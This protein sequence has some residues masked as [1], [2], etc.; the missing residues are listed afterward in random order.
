MY[1]M[2]ISQGW[3]D[4][5]T[6]IYVSAAFLQAYKST[7]NERGYTMTQNQFLTLCLEHNV[8]PEVALENDDICQALCER[9]DAL[10]EQ[11]ITEQL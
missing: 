4:S 6:Y 9:N 2:W 10:V 5:F 8:L 1:N 3:H 7:T 11:L